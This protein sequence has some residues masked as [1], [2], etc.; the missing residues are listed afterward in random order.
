MTA[1]TT[2]EMSTHEAKSKSSP[3]KDS[4][5]AAKSPAQVQEEGNSLLATGKSCLM[6]GNLPSAVSY[7][8]EA[9]E[10]LA[11]QFGY[12][13]K[14]CGESYYY[15]GKSLLELSRLESGVLA[16][17]LKGVPAENEENSDSYQFEDAE[18][19]STD[20]KSKVQVKVAEAFDYNFMTN[21]IVKEEA[22]MENSESESEEE[23]EVDESHGKMETE[24]N[25]EDTMN[26]ANSPMK[27]S[28]DSGKKE[29][30][31]EDN[32]QL[33][34]EMLELSKMIFSKLI[35]S[36]SKGKDFY[37][38]RLYSTLLALGEVSIETEN[39]KQAIEDLKLCL[40]M[41]EISGLGVPK[42]ARIAAETHY[43][44]A[45]AHV[46][47]GG[48]QDSIDC[49]KSAIYILTERVKALWLKE[50][51]SSPRGKAEIMKEIAELEV[52]IPDI[53]DKFY[54]IKDMKK[55]ASAAAKV[56]GGKSGDQLDSS[57]SE[58]TPVSIGVK[59]KAL[60]G[61]VSNKKMLFENAEALPPQTKCL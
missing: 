61:V 20:E 41:Q 13:A 59:R 56:K 12:A 34:W 38:E 4:S 31:D 9:C 55:A 11:T 14:E 3:E 26:K 58:K 6:I 8:A 49:L 32:L 1:S 5:Q 37:E 43:Q 10:L 47:Q 57:K 24:A 42:D 28:K 17:A 30:E 19:L 53:Q 27:E 23:A 21:E 54:D 16:N 52:L 7:F 35:E 29:V 46:Y 18:K 48:F 40:K 2:S 25:N 15:Y 44:L 60:E 33:A 50:S 22:E 45:L 36:G 39:H 51:S